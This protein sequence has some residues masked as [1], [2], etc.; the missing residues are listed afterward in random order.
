MFIFH[1]VNDETK[2]TIRAARLLK[3]P[4]SKKIARKR[5]LN[6]NSLALPTQH[7]LIDT[8]CKYMRGSL[9]GR[10]M[11]TSDRVKVSLLR[12]GVTGAE[13]ER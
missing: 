11:A 13:G 3:K 7:S 2:Q 10:L 8:A 9:C 4:A 5:S 1:R 12:W 6:S